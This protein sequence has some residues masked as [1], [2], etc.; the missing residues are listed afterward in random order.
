M[1]NSLLN[2]E[3]SIIVSIKGNGVYWYEGILS[4]EDETTLKLRNVVIRD[5]VGMFRIDNLETV[6]INKEYV[7]SCNNV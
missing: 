3:V 5:Y 7:I 4:D 2:Q 6:I 1:Y